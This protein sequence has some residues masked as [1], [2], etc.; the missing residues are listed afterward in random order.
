MCYFSKSTAKVQ[1]FVE[2]VKKLGHNQ[3]NKQGRNALF[4]H[5]ILSFL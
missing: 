5:F 1:H 3:K 4:E 2:F